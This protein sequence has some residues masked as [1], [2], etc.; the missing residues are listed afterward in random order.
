MLLVCVTHAQWTKVQLGGSDFNPGKIVFVDGQ[1][2]YVGSTGMVFRSTDAGT[3]FSKFNAGIGDALSGCTGMVK[4]GDRLYASFGGN[5]GRGVYYSVD[6][7]QT[8]V[9]DT[10]G[11][12]D[13]AGVPVKAF[14]RRLHKFKD[15]Y[16]LAI[17]ESNYTLYKRPEDAAWKVFPVPGD[18]RTPADIFFDGDT[19]F[20]C[21]VSTTV[22]MTAFTSDFGATWNYRKGTGKSPLSKIWRNASG[23][24]LYA[25]NADFAKW[26]QEWLLRSTDNGFTWDTVTPRNTTAVTAVY[27]EGDVVLASFGGSF[28]AADSTNKIILSTDR[29]STWSDISANYRSTVAFGFHSVNSLVLFGNTV[30]AGIDLSTGIIKRTV[31]I[32]T[33]SVPDYSLG[34]KESSVYPNPTCGILRLSEPFIGERYHIV[35]IHGRIVAQGVINDDAID[36]SAIPPGLYIVRVEGPSRVAHARVVRM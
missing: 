7:G 1:T 8:W 17:L 32:K 3:S 14:A 22:P 36:M 29:G 33:T 2:I 24:E 6:Q 4:I 12:K 35:D 30:I 11:W 34:D 20:V 15:S 13:I 19:V 5:G 9:A 23:K 25:S 26:G 10:A 31:D 21:Q 16:L 18:Y 28:S 27:A